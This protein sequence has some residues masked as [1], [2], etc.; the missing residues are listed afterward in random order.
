MKS[1]SLLRGCLPIFWLLQVAAVPGAPLVFTPAPDGS[2]TF[3]T[4][5]LRGTL[6]E[7]G[8]PLGLTMVTHTPSGQRLDRSNG[9]LSHYRVFSKGVRYGDGAWDWPGQ[10]QR[11][12]DGAVQ[13]RWPAT[14]DRPFEFGA[15]Y[16][17][18]TADT[19]DLETTVRAEKDLVGFESFLASYFSEGFTNAAV[20]VARSID[21]EQQPGFIPTRLSW[22]AWQMFPSNDACLSLIRDGRW[23]LEPNPVNWT[24]RPTLAEPLC[25]R[26]HVQTGLTAIL[27][28]P[29]GECFAIAGPHQTEGHYSMYLSLFGLNLSAGQSAVARSRLIVAVGLSEVQIVQRYRSYRE[30]PGA[31]GL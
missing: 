28:S 1:I 7:K 14:A 29:P 2:F 18:R 3:D 16:R 12:D 17:W 31:G 8:K 4:G 27:M 13:V 21:N 26:R 25:V 22:G 23:R 11:L 30:G 5:I 9:L 20:Y 10:A 6:H 19:L 24:I 15:T